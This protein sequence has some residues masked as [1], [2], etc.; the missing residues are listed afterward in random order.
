MVDRKK[1]NKIITKHLP[2]A[3]GT[4]IDNMKFTSDTFCEVWDE[5]QKELLDRFFECGILNV[6]E[7]HLELEKLNN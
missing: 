4:L 1:I 2:K 3:T 5:A 7:Y 6:S